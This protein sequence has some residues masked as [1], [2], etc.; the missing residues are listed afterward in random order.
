MSNSYQRRFV[1]ARDS[2]NL[3]AQEHPAYLL[4]NK[5][6]EEIDTHKKFGKRKLNY[7]WIAW[8]ST[9][10]VVQIQRVVFVRMI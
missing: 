7:A 1:W 8:G 9:G 2:D 3:N 5:K 6:Y 10:V 4:L